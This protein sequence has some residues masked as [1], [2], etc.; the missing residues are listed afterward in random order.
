MHLAYTSKYDYQNLNAVTLTVPTEI[1]CSVI[2]MIMQGS[3]EG[4]FFLFSRMPFSP[5][6]PKF[7]HLLESSHQDD[8][9]KC[10]IVSSILF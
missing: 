6:N 1:G 7:D 2:I 3:R 9:N 4:L 8:N 5:P 10:R